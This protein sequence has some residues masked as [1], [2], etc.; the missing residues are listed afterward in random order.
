MYYY[1]HTLYI[2]RCKNFSKGGIIL[3]EANGMKKADKEKHIEDKTI[4]D[5]E[6]MPVMETDGK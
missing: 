1:L 3:A 4:T 6:K 2:H 5:V